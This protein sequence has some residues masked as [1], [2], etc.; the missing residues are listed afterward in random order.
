MSHYS[1]DMDIVSETLNNSVVQVLTS[2]ISLAGTL[3]S[4]VVISPLLTLITVIL[5]PLMII[6][7][8]FIMK[9]SRLSN[10]PNSSK[11]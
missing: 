9:Y 1:N 8:R 2:V 11:P 3:I 4:M 5:V 10:F 7:A 6:L